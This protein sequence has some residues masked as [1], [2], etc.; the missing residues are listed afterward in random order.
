M[1]ICMQKK[2]TLSLPSF[3]RYC[4]ITANLGNFWVLW[5]CLAMQSESDTINLYTTFIFI[6]TQKINFTPMFFWRYCEDMQTS[7]FG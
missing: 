4:K 2:A 1:F 3:L 5:A 7:Y 6:C